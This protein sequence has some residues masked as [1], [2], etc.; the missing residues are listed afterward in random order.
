MAKAV[1]KLDAIFGSSKGLKL[2]E[3]REERHQDVTEKLA[4]TDGMAVSD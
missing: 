1:G 2:A 3:I 4:L